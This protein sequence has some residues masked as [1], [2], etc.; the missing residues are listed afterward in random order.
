MLNI[1]DHSSSMG[2]RPC[3]YLQPTMLHCDAHHTWIDDD[4]YQSQCS[5]NHTLNPTCIM[6]GI[7][8][9]SDSLECHIELELDKLQEVV[10]ALMKIV[11]TWY[12]SSQ[13]LSSSIVPYKIGV[14]QGYGVMQGSSLCLNFHVLMSM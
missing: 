10:V 7:T 13:S 5:E 3:E 1:L 9:V 2:M 14:L 11:M 12:A 6:T 8:Q 4:G